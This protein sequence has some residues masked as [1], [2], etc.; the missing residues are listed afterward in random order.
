MQ[1]STEKQPDAKAGGARKKTT[2]EKYFDDLHSDGKLT[3]IPVKHLYFAENIDF[4][5]G[6]DSQVS[7]RACIRIDPA[8]PQTMNRTWVCDFIPAWQVFE[9]TYIP[10]PESMPITEMLPAVHVRRFKRF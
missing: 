9:V 6:G 10:G 4:N 5:G 8:N 1:E 3:R 2:A 7:N